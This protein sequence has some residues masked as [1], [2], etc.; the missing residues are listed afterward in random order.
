MHGSV[1]SSLAPNEGL[2]WSAHFTTHMCNPTQHCQSSNKLRGLP[3]LSCSRDTSLSG[4]L[5]PEVLLA[6]ENQLTKYK[7]QDTCSPA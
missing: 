1:V 5:S 6:Y 3:I 7:Q 2:H 4:A